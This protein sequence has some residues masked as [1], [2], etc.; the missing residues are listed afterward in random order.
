MLS[1]L[2]HPVPTILREGGRVG[3]CSAAGHAAY[4][5]GGYG[6]AKLKTE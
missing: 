1:G 6:W 3:L 2:P 5:R 4:L